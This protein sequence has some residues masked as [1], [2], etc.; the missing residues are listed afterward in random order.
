MSSPESASLLPLSPTLSPKGRGSS[1]ATF[2][3]VSFTGHAAVW[4]RVDRAGDVFRRGAFGAARVVPLLAGHRGAA[5]GE[6][7]V[8]E[9]ALG[10]LVEASASVAVRV[11]DGLSVGYRLGAAR[12]GAWRELLA[13]ELVEV[14]L[15][16]QPMQIAARV[17]RVEPRAAQLPEDSAAPAGGSR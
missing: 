16:R 9:D 4:D 1:E 10:L 3:R 6:A 17:Q 2:P 12:Q 5:V 14:S 8:S 13:V 15:V 11:G 7:R